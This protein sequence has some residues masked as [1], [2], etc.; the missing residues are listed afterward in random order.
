[1]KISFIKPKHIASN[2][3]CTIHRSG[4]L[5]FSKA[6]I[7]ELNV[8][9]T[10]FVKIGMNEEDTNDKNLY[11]LILKEKDD[12]AFKVNKAGRYY[13]LNTKY[14]FEDLMED[15]RTKKIIY[16]IQKIEYEGDIIYKLNRRE[17]NR[18]NNEK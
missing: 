4:K 17:L 18:K 8:D 5:G 7:K 6:A 13:Y 16:D 3:K 9:E 14:L 1:M 12:D 11:M 2:V 10:T 15:Y